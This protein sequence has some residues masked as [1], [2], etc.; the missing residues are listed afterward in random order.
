MVQPAVGWSGQTVYRSSPNS[1]SSLSWS[2]LILVGVVR[3]CGAPSFLGRRVHD[4]HFLDLRQLPQ[5]R[6]D[7][8]RLR[9]LEGSLQKRWR[10][11]F[12]RPIRTRPFLRIREGAPSLLTDRHEL[13]GGGCA[14]QRLLCVVEALGEPADARP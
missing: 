7:Y 4:L 8:R 2:T 6:R 11:S 14:H 13:P 12:G 9:M 3:A 5:L 1:S 10:V